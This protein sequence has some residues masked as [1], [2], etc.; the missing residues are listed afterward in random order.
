MN[1]VFK[2]QIISVTVAAGLFLGC[3]DKKEKTSPEKSKPDVVQPDEK[4]PEVKKPEVKPVETNPF[5]EKEYKTTYE[6]PPFEKIKPEHYLPAFKKGMDEQKKAIESI[7]ADKIVPSFK[8]VIER[9]ENSDDLLQKVANVFFN[10]ASADANDKLLEIKKEVVP[11]LTK[12]NDDINFNAELFAKV[13]MVY[14]NQSKENLSVEQKMVLK[15]YYTEFVRGGANLKPEEKTK[16][17]AL[18][19]ELAQK[20]LAFNENLLKDAREWKLVIEKKEELAGLPDSVISAAADAAKAAKLDGKWVFNLDKPSWIPFLTYAENRTLRDKIYKGWYKRGDRGDKYDNNKLIAE[21]ASL[22]VKKARIMGYKTWAEFRLA[23]NMAKTP[24]KVMELLNKLWKPA[25]AMGKKESAELQGMIRRDKKRF[26]LQSHD[27]WFY[28]ERLR[29]AKYAL[30]DEALRP[31]FVLENVRMGAFYTAE[32]LFGI[33]FRERTDL[34]KYHKEVKT[35]EVVKDG[36]VIGIYLADY[37]PR[38]G[39]RAGAWMSEYRKQMKVN[40]ERVIPIITNVCNF[41]RPSGEVPALLSFDEVT[42]LFHEFGHALHGLLSDVTYRKVSGTE[43]PLDFVELPSQLLE[44][45]ALE[46]QVLKVYAKHYKTGEV[47]PKKLVDKIKKSKY[48][49]QGFQ[50]VEYLAAAFLD[51]AWHSLTDDKIVNTTRFENSVLKKLGLIPEIIARYRSTYFAHVVGGYSA[52]YYSYIWAAV[53]D[54]DAFAAFEEKK[55]IF[56]AETA[57]K[58]H[59]FILS[60]GGSDESMD[61]YKKFRGRE[62]RIEP[63]LKNRGLKK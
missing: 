63:L 41:S 48:F 17:G 20:Q 35:F 52:G 1:S 10:I 40:G 29:K 3:G 62:P 60:Q 13:K 46:E 9:L 8:S 24:A 5:L 34:P 33:T 58:L 12:H 14:D 37:H 22:R 32:K 55:D 44:H 49:N 47:I 30:D 28:A 61:L 56:H 4:G 53:L 7:V 16:L 31:Y 59:D 26:K 42:T 57:R 27:W 38:P 50:T 36:K 6:M 2:K 11:M 15:R 21:I 45:W 23:D 54:N 18:N 43:T 19:K 25:I 51:M 39:K